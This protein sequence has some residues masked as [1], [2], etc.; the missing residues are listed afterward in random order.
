MRK[1][2][3]TVAALALGIAFAGCAGDDAEMDEGAALGADEAEVPTEV[4]D[5]AL[6]AWQ[7]RLDNPGAESDDF[8]MAEDEDGSWRV[9]TGPAGITWRPA[10]L[11]QS[12]DFTARATFT[13]MQAQ[14]GHREA[15][16]LLIGGFH[17][18]SPDQ[19]YT[20][21]LVRGTG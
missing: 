14:P 12:G 7:V 5:A 1:R 19:K 6:E 20:Y 11:V 10:D 2:T 8:V 18:E 13:E 15:Y 4:D 21:F 9:T 16:G 17:L 3:T